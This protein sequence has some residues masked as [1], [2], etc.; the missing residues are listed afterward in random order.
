MIQESPKI[1]GMD[2]WLLGAAVSNAWS[3]QITNSY[4]R[5][6][7]KALQ[8]SNRG[9]NHYSESFVTSKGSVWLTPPGFSNLRKIATYGVISNNIRVTTTIGYQWAESVQWMGC[10]FGKVSLS[11]THQ[12]ELRATSKPFHQITYFS[13]TSSNCDERRTGKKEK[14]KVTLSRANVHRERLPEIE[15]RVYEHQSCG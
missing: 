4:I 8:C 9:P 14:E 15:S 2:E 7:H 6:C 5:S 11:T 10:H 1:L 3:Q 13:R 12:E